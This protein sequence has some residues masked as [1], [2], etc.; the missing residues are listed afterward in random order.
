[1]EDVVHIGTA[2]GAKMMG[3]EGVGV[4]EV[5]QAADI[6]VY[7]LN[8]PRHFGLHDP[9]LGPVASGGRTPLRAL[10]VHGRVVVERDTIPGLDLAALRADAQ[11]LVSMML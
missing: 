7:D 9:A 2:G 11:R 10:L 4:L 5:G 6:A 3:L 1:V 8:E